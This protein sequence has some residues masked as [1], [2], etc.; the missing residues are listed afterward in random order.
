ME[1]LSRRHDIRWYAVHT[2]PQAEAE[3]DLNIRRLGYITW[4]PFHRVRC[5]R[6]RPGSLAYRVEWIERPYFPRY[7]FVA[8][9]PRERYYEPIGPIARADGVSSVVSFQGGPLEIPHA[10]MDELMDRSDG[11]GLIGEDDLTTR[12]R[13]APGQKVLLNVTAALN[14]LLAQVSLDNGKEIRLWV[15]MFGTKRLVRV[16]PDKVA[17]I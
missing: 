9:R 12:A 13:L 2:R 8:V 16:S 4:Y 15:E 14:G 5:R 17:A 7:T 1:M 6:K 3:A 11:S 10:V